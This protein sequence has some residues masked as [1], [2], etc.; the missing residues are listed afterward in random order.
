MADA[1]LAD[2][3]S[4][5]SEGS[6]SALV[7]VGSGSA[8]VVVGSGADVVVVVEVFDVEDV[9]EVVE[10]FDVDEVFDVVEVFD[11]EEVFDEV[12][13]LLELVDDGVE[14]VVVVVTTTLPSASVVVVVITSVVASALPPDVVEAGSAGEVVGC[15]F[16]PSAL[17]VEAGISVPSTTLEALLVASAEELLS[18]PVVMAKAG[19]ATTTPAA[20]PPMMGRRSNRGRGARCLPTYLMSRSRLPGAD[21]GALDWSCPR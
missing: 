2:E 3:L 8:L 6:G 15:V 4:S 5:L 21:P 17:S 18:G 9:L 20:T 11:V 14:V 13:V 16:V 19:T 7:V 12:F 10:V 1:L